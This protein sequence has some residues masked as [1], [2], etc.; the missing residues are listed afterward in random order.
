MD[1]R[2]TG[3]LTPRRQN[4][5]EPAHVVGAF[6]VDAEVFCVR[7]LVRVAA[8]DDYRSLSSI[9]YLCR[10]LFSDASAVGEDRPSAG[11]DW[12]RDWRRFLQPPLKFVE[13]IVDV[14]RA[15]DAIEAQ[16]DHFDA[17]LSGFIEEPHAAFDTIGVR[18]LQV[19]VSP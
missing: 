7:P 1:N 2:S 8:A 9:S 6:G 15:T 16:A 12:H 14:G 17:Y 11:I 13:P 5:D 10:Q 3:R 4:F 19:G 18:C